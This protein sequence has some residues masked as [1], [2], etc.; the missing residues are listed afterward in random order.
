M[1]DSMKGTKILIA[2]DDLIS[3]LMLISALK[4][5]DYE[6]VVVTNGKEALEILLQEDSPLL[7]ILDWIMP[8]MDGIDVIKTLQKEKPESITYMI[9]LTSKTEKDDVICGLE[10]GAHEILMKDG[11]QLYDVICGLEAGAHDYIRKPFDIDELWARIRVDLRTATLQKELLETQKILEYKAV[12]D[13]LTDCL[14]RRGILERLEEEIERSLRSG[15]QF[16][17]ALCDLDHFK[18][19]NDTYGHQIGDNVLKYFVQIIYRQLRP[20]DQLG[21]LGGEEFLI[22]IPD[23]SDADAV[24]TLERLRHSVQ[25]AEIDTYSEKLKITVSIGGII[26]KG[27]DNMDNIIKIVDDTMYTAKEKGRNQVYFGGVE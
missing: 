22:I 16:C 2:E 7:A 3:R 5:W 21:R 4:R 6:P 12:H 23:I 13:P 24:S 10:A 17:V 15:S 19:V 26:V 8:E 20:Y 25:E 9:I 18:K 11:W 14:N 1:T 27:K